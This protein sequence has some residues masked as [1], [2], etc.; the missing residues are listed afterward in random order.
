MVRAIIMRKYV[1]VG[2]VVQ[3]VIPSHCTGSA[4]KQT[5]SYKPEV[6]MVVHVGTPVLDS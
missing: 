3:L 2:S 4:H 5:T 6:S 1:N